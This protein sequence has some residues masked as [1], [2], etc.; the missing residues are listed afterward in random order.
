[1]VFDRRKR[2][3]IW[4]LDDEAA[5][6]PGPEPEPWE[7]WLEP[8]SLSLDSHGQSYGYVY[9]RYSATF[10]PAEAVI[11]WS[12]SDL[13]LLRAY[14]DRDEMTCYVGMEVGLSPGEYTADVICEV[15][16]YGVTKTLTCPVSIVVN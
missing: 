11:T 5:P 13:N 1:M 8:A 16:F 15:Q 10:N 6:G 2:L 12:S 14:K 3:L 9:L 4:M 7:V